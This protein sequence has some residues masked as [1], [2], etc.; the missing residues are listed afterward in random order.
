M[1]VLFIGGTG[2]I[3]TACTALAAERGIDLYLLNRG[4]RPADVPPGVRLLTGDINDD[5]AGVKALLAEHSFDVVV[6][7]IAF[8]PDQVE[9]DI[10]MFAGRTGQ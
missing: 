3:S 5:P 6:D 9:R 7:W 2:T 8:T 4:Q 1:K 10:D